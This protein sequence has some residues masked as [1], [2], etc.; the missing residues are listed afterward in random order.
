MGAPKRETTRQPVKSD[1]GFKSSVVAGQMAQAQGL[2]L[3]LEHALGGILECDFGVQLATAQTTADVVFVDSEM[4][5]L[6]QF[7]ATI[8]RQARVV[9]LIVRE[10]SPVPS[11]WVEGQVDDVLVYPFRSLEVLGKLRQYQRI[12]DNRDLTEV[13]AAYMQVVEKL[14]ANLELAARLQKSKLPL[15]FPDVRG[16]KV[17]SR[18]LAG[19]RSGGDY[20]DLAE[21]RD[22]NQVAIVLTDASSYR[23]SSALMDSLPRVMSALSIEDSRS[24]IGSARRIRD[25][26]L[27][28][29]TDQD[30][31][32]LFYAMLSRKDYRLKF[33]NLGG[34]R[35]FY[36]SPGKVFQELKTQ[37]EPIQRASGIRTEEEGEVTLEPE[38]RLAIFSDGFVQIA[39]GVRGLMDV[40]NRLRSKDAKDSINELAFK[41][42]SPLTGED[43]LPA[44]DCTAVIFDVD[45]RLIR[46]A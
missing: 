6:N 15:R 24:C 14:Q 7:L 42:K 2:A 34:S 29:L 19:I 40:L 41:V 9:Y 5:N 38:G 46:L 45:S 18:Y 27:A 4:P 11:T 25:G 21:S 3:E 39:G 26:I 13:N 35:A 33:V 44:R 31:L 32:S 22:G 16:F 8:D 23:L 30:R 17:T 12:L 37:G 28:T 10:D 36:A 1:L 20:A 43:D